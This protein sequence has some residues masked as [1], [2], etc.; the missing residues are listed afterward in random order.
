MCVTPEQIERMIDDKLAA[1]SDRLDEKFKIL[2]HD[3]QGPST[4]TLARLA[5]QDGKIDNIKHIIE[6]F[7]NS[8]EKLFQKLDD[9]SDI[10]T[11]KLL[12]VYL[13]EEKKKNAKAYIWQVLSKWASFSGKLAS[14][15]ALI[16][17]IV[18]V[19]K[20]LSEHM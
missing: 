12:P 14:L 19:V 18:W 1:F 8:M 16:M 15:A 4:I 13:E 5:E 6:T 9:I 11:E 17:G 3:A 7:G 2:R 10:V 20:V